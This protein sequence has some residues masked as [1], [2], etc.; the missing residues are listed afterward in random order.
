MVTRGLNN[1]ILKHYDQIQENKKYE[2]MKKPMLI[3]K[4][5]LMLFIGMAT[6][7]VFLRSCAEEAYNPGIQPPVI[8]EIGPEAAFPSQV[9]VIYGKNF[10]SAAAGNT[11]SFNGTA[12]TV[13]KTTT[14]AITTTVPDGATSGNVTVSTNNLTSEGFPFTVTEPIIPTITSID[15]T[16]GKV[17]ATVIITGTNFSTTPGRNIV[18]FNGT[19]ATVTASTETEITTTVPAGATTGPVTVTVDGESNGIVFT[20]I[21]ANQLIVQITQSSDDAEE[22]GENGAMCN[23]SSDLEL[24]EFDTWTQGGVAQGLQT[25]GLRFNEITIPQG[26]KILAANLTFTCDV[27]GSN[28]AQLTIYGENIAN[29]ETFKDYNLNPDDHSFNIT[30]RP[31]TLANAV[32]D[33]PEWTTAGDAGLAQQTTDLAAIVQE[34]VDRGDWISGNSMV[35]ILEPS[36]PSLGVTSSSAGREA[37]AIDGT[38]ATK[39]TVI[40]E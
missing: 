1:I 22:G 32:W 35:F 9:V 7:I 31:R 34:I 12:A 18:S 30:T 2:I 21:E 38:A 15:P 23:T 20:V 13:I 39:L 28:P 8:T 5:S 29:A 40:Y 27:G 10:S 3:T 19:E 36:G 25:I 6:V 17:G 37:E 16:T 24:G 4:R 33:I 26:S 11:V 14:L